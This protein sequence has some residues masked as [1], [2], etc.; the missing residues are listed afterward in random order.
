MAEVSFLPLAR[1]TRKRTSASRE[2]AAKTPV[3]GEASMLRSEIN[4]V[5]RQDY[6]NVISPC[7]REIARN[8]LKKYCSRNNQHSYNND[9]F[10]ILE[11]LD[12]Q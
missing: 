4:R 6:E 2:C 1:K 11:K 10:N 12:L 5:G 9:F 7:L 3:E 8:A